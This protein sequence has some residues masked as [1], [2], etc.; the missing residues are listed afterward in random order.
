MAEESRSSKTTFEDAVLTF[1]ALVLVAQMFQNGKEMLDEKFEFDL[2]PGQYLVA[3]AALSADTPLGTK[4]NMPNGG[5]FFSEPGSGNADGSFAP[6]TSLEIVGGPEM[7]DGERWW[8]VEDPV[9][10]KRG[11]VPESQLIREGVGGLGPATKLGS[12]AR[13]IMDADLWEAPGSLMK[14]GSMKMGEWGELIKGPEDENGSRWWFFDRENSDDDGWVT[15]A[16]LMLASDSGWKEGSRVKATRDADLFERAGGGQI[17]GLMQ[18]GD[19]AKVLGGPVEIG[20]QYWWLIETKDGAQG[21]V[22]ESALEDG[23]AK[24]WFKGVLAVVV[25][26][27]AIVTIVLLGLI[28][29]ATIRTNQIRAHEAER[30][31]AA[32]PKHMEPRKNERWEK[33]CEHVASDN[34]NDWRLAIIEADIMLDELITRM[35]YQGQ[36]LGDRLKQATRGDIQNID[37][38]WEAHKV[39]NQ[40]AHTGS[41]YILTQREAQRVIDLYASVFNE[42]KYV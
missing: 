28:I 40:I 22:T 2:E 20:G 24:G 8:Y 5:D 32:I 39:R 35:G 19:T 36:T 31:R 10:G 23:G 38:A 1:F 26:V 7:I 30:I 3:S 4:V 14:A 21:W 33:V 18:E 11:W 17:V 42:F 41:D 25:I 34:P 15:E 37:A 29:Y 16:A 12:K 6:G 13:A 9:T 27:G